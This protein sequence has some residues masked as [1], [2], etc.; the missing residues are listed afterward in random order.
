LRV[1]AVSP[2]FAC[3]ATVVQT[4]IGACWVRPD[5]LIENAGGTGGA[6]PIRKTRNA[7]YPNATIKRDRQHVSCAYGSARRFD[8]QAVQP[9]IPRDREVG[10]S[11]A[12]AHHPRMPKPFVYPLS[13]VRQCCQGP[14]V[15]F[16]G[17]RLELRLERGEFCEGRVGVWFFAA[18]LISRGPGPDGTFLV[19]TPRAIGSV[20]LLSAVRPLRTFGTLQSLTFRF[21]AML[22][23]PATTA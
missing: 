16:L 11:V 13:I 21:L 1:Q 17:I 23:T 10:R 9:N 22:R 4:P 8:A 14:S 3:F 6:A 5:I 18:A 19:A 2:L 15:W 20:P 7:Q 12:R